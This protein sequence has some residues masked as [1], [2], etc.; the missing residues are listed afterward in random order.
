M[1]KFFNLFA[2]MIITF[3][4]ISLTMVTGAS[5]KDIKVGAVIN[6]TGPLS[7]WGQSCLQGPRGREV[8]EE[9]FHLR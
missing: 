3:G 7:S 6:L 8:C 1:R 9:I 5:A 4:F 2:V